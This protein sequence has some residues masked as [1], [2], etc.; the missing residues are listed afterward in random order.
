MGNEIDRRKFVI[1]L[2]AGLGIAS[3]VASSK[4]AASLP[5][6][7]PVGT[8]LLPNF[9]FL[10]SDDQSYS[11]AG[12]NGNS[13]VHTPNI[14]RLA[15]EG[16]RFDRAFAPSPSCSPSRSA[17]LT[18]QSPHETGTARF[19]SPM[20]VAQKTILEYLKG[21]RYYTGA[22][23]KVHQGAEFWQ[24]WDFKGL[25]KPVHT[26][27]DARPKD[28]PFYLHIG[29]HDPHRPYLPGERYPEK[30]PRVAIG[31]PSFLPDTPA[32]RKD[33]AHYYEAIERLDMKV[34]QILNLLEKYGL[35]ENTLVI[36]TSDQGMSFPGA[37]GTLYEP[38]LHVPLIARW[39]GKIKPG[40]VS[41]DLVS[42]V[43]LAPTWMQA[44]GLSVPA[45]MDG[46]SFL[47]LLLGRNFEPRQAV[48]A[49][50]NFHTHLDLIRSVRTARYKLIQN[51]LPE[52]PYLP[53]SDIARSPSWRSIENLMH[54]GKLS[55]PLLQRYFKKPRP[56]EEFY[57]LQNDLGEMKNL[58][59][60]PKYKSEL[61]HL[62]QL[63]SRWMIATHD[64]LPPPILPP[65]ID[66]L[67]E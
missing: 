63:L 33:L 66:Q 36:F 13:A 49:E 31:V 18:G 5:V 35:A 16:L 45:A 32:V 3:F 14:D 56:E 43:D 64:F 50:R 26:F 17:I 61:L 12:C 24:R 39:P 29:Y 1:G 59:N 28:R 52:M 48:Y 53:L 21:A 15:R 38:G 40:G 9:V 44:A 2:S 30:N 23:K 37:K 67:M 46:R 22:F 11:S 20:P 7:D 57:D 6:A 8:K 54:Q 4:R 55:A 65:D 60:D 27:L 58:A 41:S 42:L 10:I 34:G 51:Y 62:Q 19:R 47:P 25:H